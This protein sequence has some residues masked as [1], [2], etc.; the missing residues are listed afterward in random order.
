M[1]KS[2]VFGVALLGLFLTFPL[3][4]AG[5]P[6]SESQ[7][8]ENKCDE[9]I[10]RWKQPN[11]WGVVIFKSIGQNGYE[12]S[13][14]ELG[15]LAAY[16]FTMGETTIRLKCVKPGRYEGQ[17]KWRWTD[18]RMEWRND[19]FTL[20]GDRMKADM[21]ELERVRKNQDCDSIIGA[22]IR[23]SDKSAVSFKSTG[24]SGYEASI[25]EIGGLAAY[26]FTVGETTIR[27][28]CVKPGQYEGQVKWG[29]TD[30]RKEWR[31]DAFTLEGDQLK[32]PS[33]D[34][35]RR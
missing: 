23:Q 26:G 34:L 29:W 8:P 2:L 3:A 25:V 7:N 6:F 32:S 31:N 4:K 15:S 16:R 30:G 11:D 24:Q 1:N 33:L 12:A 20:D 27:L 21:G 22:W 19:A 9:I 14:V 10:G 13:I 17:V 28:K 35:V 18:G 5:A